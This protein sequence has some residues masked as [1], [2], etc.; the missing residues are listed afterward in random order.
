MSK[1]FGIVEVRSGCSFGGFSGTSIF[2]SAEASDVVAI[3]MRVFRRSTFLAHLHQSGE[4]TG[5]TRAVQQSAKVSKSP[6]LRKL[7]DC[8]TPLTS[9]L[10]RHLNFNVTPFKFSASGDWAQ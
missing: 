1:A 4:S 10:Q 3:L 2:Q 6:R 5:A 8:V 9:G 7:Y